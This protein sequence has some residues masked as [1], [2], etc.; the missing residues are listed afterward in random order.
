DLASRD[1][2]NLV[3]NRLEQSLTH[4]LPLARIDRDRAERT[5]M[6]AGRARLQREVEQMRLADF[7]LHVVDQEPSSPKVV[8]HSGVGLRRKTLL[9]GG[10]G[11]GG[12][13]R[14]W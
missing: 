8:E 2:E 11:G 4:H 7:R 6:V 14:P 1:R 10:K 5:T 9:G 12:A 13:A 3:E